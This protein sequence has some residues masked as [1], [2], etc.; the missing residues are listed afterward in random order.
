MKHYLQ[1]N[2]FSADE[3]AY[4]LERAAFIKKKFKAYEKYQPLADRTLA[5]IFEKAS[6]RTRVSFEAGM[7]Q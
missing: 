3:Y 5:M 4:L 6:T 7:Y 1:F 2:D